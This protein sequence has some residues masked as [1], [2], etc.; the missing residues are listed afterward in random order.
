MDTCYRQLLLI[1]G[2]VFLARVD[3]MENN[4]AS[5]AGRHVHWNDLL[6]YPVPDGEIEMKLIFEDVKAA[7]LK[8]DL[9][10]LSTCAIKINQ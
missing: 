9:L 2:F 7:L 8:S 3:R 10:S 4:T 6:P 5:S 1:Y